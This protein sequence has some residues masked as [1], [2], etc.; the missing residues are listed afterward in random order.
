MS[1]ENR[2]DRVKICQ[3]NLAMFEENMWRLYD[4]VAGDESLFYHRQIGHKQS[5]ASWV[6][7]GE[8]PRTEVRQRC[9][10]PKTMFSIFFESNGVFDHICSLFYFLNNYQ[11]LWNVN[12]RVKKRI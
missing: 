10:E 12:L 4:V 6:A 11:S 8:S 2:Q 3:E 5:N 1:A 7:E 9:F